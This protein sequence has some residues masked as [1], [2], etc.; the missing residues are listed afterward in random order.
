MSCSDIIG[1]KGED[2][3]RFLRVPYLERPPDLVKHA[4]Y[5][6]IITMDLETAEVQGCAQALSE[7]CGG[8]VSAHI[9]GILL[10]VVYT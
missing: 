7:F 4:A 3:T 10:A 1:E 8:S 6:K 9:A 2:G 5:L